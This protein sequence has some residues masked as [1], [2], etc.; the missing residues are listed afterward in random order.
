MTI[1]TTITS[2]AATATPALFKIQAVD[3]GTR[4][5]SSLMQ[6]PEAFIFGP[7]GVFDS[8][9]GDEFYINSDCQLVVNTG[10]FAGFT[11]CTLD[12]PDDTQAV[13]FEPDDEEARLSCSVDADFHLLCQSEQSNVLSI[14][15]GAFIFGRPDNGFPGC[16]NIGSSGVSSG[17]VVHPRVLPM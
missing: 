7:Y 3:S 9:V 13:Y 4:F 15:T 1:T 2:A 14:Y 16:L 12:D 6:V 10:Y 17:G 5:D 11:A 8:S